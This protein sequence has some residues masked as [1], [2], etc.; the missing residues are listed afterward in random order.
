MG[1]FNYSKKSKRT[2]PSEKLGF[3][4]NEIKVGRYSRADFEPIEAEVVKLWNKPDTDEINFYAKGS[5]GGEG[6]LGWITNKEI[7][8]H[9]KMDGL[10]DATIK[11][12]DSN[13]FYVDL[14]LKNE[15][16]DA[17]KEKKE[18]MKT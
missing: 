17:E 18:R 5:S 2:E 6:L 9:L 15:F 16:K 10:Y 14:R 1:I 8:D 12:V 4:S 13:D 11:E 3:D 7:V